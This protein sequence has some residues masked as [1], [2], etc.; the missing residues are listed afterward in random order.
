MSVFEVCFVVKI[1][2]I[3]HKKMPVFPHEIVVFLLVF[4]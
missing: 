1:G 3:F 4:R 2:V